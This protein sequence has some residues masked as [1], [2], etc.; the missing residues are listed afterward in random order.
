[1]LAMLQAPLASTTV[2]QFQSPRS[3]YNR[4][5]VAVVADGGDRGPGFYRR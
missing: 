1:M 2:R 4:V 3:V 5:A